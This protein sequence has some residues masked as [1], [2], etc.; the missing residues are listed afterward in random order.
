M[1]IVFAMFFTLLVV[2]CN[3]SPNAHAGFDQFA[4]VGRTVTLDGSKSRDPDGD[5]LRYRWE[6]NSPG[7]TLSSETGKRVDATITQ[8]GEYEIKLRV[9]DGSASST[10][11]TMLRA[12]VT[13]HVLVGSRTSGAPLLEFDSDFQLVREFVQ[14]SPELEQ[15][16]VLVRRTPDG[17][18][19]VIE[20]VESLP[21]GCRRS[22]ERYSSGG[23]HV[24]TVYPRDTRP[25]CE[26]VGVGEP[27]AVF[28]TDGSIFIVDDLKLKL[29]RGQE[30]AEEMPLDVWTVGGRDF[31]VSRGIFYVT[32]LRTVFET[33]PGLVEV[34]SDG[35]FVRYV[36]DS[37]LA[38]SPGRMDVGSMDEIAIAN[39]PMG[40]LFNPEMGVFS[41]FESTPGADDP[42]GV[43]IA[44][45]G[46]VWA[47]SGVSIAHTSSSG[48]AFFTYPLSGQ[49]IAVALI[50]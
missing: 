6:V 28:E 4:L 46:S 1:R 21:F 29:V 8:A 17:T 44:P 34:S 45:D 27:A 23:E 25:G 16:P 14:Y 40:L 24:E 39:D 49:P 19:L 32:L 38:G 36:L 30:V 43:A 12:D 2:A 10:D 18:L 22:V 41:T 37:S 13:P 7:V 5:S 31:V 47:V 20:E 50:Y 48:T 11:R 3:R 35:V 33:P 26:G 42:T 15:W 9:S